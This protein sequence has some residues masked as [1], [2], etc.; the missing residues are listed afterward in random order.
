[1]KKIIQSLFIL[2]LIVKSLSSIYY[3]QCHS[4][5]IC[6]IKIDTSISNNSW[7][8]GP[9]QK[10]IF[11]NAINGQNVIITDTIN[12]YPVND[13]SVFYL[14][15]SLSN[16]FPL[17][18]HNVILLGYYYVNSDTLTD[19]GKIE[20][21]NDQGNTWIDVLTHPMVYWYTP[22]PNL[23][24][25]SNGWVH[26]KFNISNYINQLP[27]HNDSLIYRFT[28]ISDNLETFKDG[29]MFD[30]LRDNNLSQSIFSVEN[31]NLFFIYPNPAQNDVF[32]TFDEQL[33]QNK[34][35]FTI[36][37]ALGR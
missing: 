24:G 35:S 36:V 18:H 5:S 29:L 7:Q 25:N 37:D 23:T 19:F 11:N 27:L 2:I 30:D 12:N 3:A 6:N 26:F 28:F 4:S 34:Y 17:Q 13:S 8:I 33:N 22:K 14:F 15:T 10:N 31:S 20:V 1:M 21:S 16:P 32:I 9:P